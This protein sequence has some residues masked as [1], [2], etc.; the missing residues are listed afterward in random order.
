[1]TCGVFL[2]GCQHPPTHHKAA[3]LSNHTPHQNVRVKEGGVIE[4]VWVTSG[5]IVK[6]GDLI[7]QIL[8]PVNRE[9]NGTH[10]LS[11][12]PE[13]PEEGCTAIQENN[14]QKIVQ[15]FLDVIAQKLETADGHIFRETSSSGGPEIGN[16][17][18][19]GF[20]TLVQ[21]FVEGSNVT[22][23]EEMVE[24]MRFLTLMNP[25]SPVFLMPVPSNR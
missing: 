2:S 9:M 8:T 12:Y 22:V 17:G 24:L 18:E 14:T 3:L 10:S 4:K 25:S 15:Y 1:M 23:N 13:A 6:P 19:D 16:P 21:G 5:Q 20:G 11:P 7:C